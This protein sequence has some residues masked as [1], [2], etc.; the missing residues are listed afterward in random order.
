V[1]RPR[2]RIGPTRTSP[3]VRFR[4]AINEDRTSAKNSCAPMGPVE[5]RIF[6]M[7]PLRL[8]AASH[9]TREERR[10]SCV[11]RS[12]LLGCPMRRTAVL[13]SAAASLFKSSRLKSGWAGARR[14][15]G[16]TGRGPKSNRVALSALFA[17][18]RSMM[19]AT[20]CAY[21]CPPR[22]VAMPRAFSGSAISRSV[23]APAL[24]ASRMIGARWPRS[25]PP[26]S[27]RPL[28]CS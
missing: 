2:A 12:F 13:C 10:P 20:D 23:R 8:V 14:T 7:D 3:D 4:T 5:P 19:F 11:T 27:S 25:D 26:R 6:C 16:P 18:A 15:V 28:R 24:W 1:T 17:Y 21:Y 22:A 9:G